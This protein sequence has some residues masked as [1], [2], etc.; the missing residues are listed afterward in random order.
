MS[1][2]TIRDKATGAVV[3]VST[4]LAEKMIAGGGWVDGKPKAARKGGR[5]A[6]TKKAEEPEKE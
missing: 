2:Q 1:T 3:T 4:K 6:K 5:P